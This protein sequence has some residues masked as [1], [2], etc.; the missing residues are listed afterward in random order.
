MG[1]LGNF[2]VYTLAMVGVIVVALMVF[3]N[4]TSISAGRSSKLLKVVDT[5]NIGQRKTLYIVSAGK[6]K[7]LIAGDVDRTALISKLDN[8]SEPITAIATSENEDYTTKSYSSG[9]SPIATLEPDRGSFKDTMANLSRP[10]FMDR[11]DIGIKSSM[12]AKTHRNSANKSVIK[13]IAEILKK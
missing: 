1:Y 12:T 8:V 10:G 6:E 11:S 3:K 9:D 7:F 4:A 2:I 13:S 5:L